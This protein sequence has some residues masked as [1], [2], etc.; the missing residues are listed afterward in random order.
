MV[1]LSFREVSLVGK[2][3]VHGFDHRVV[4]ARVAALL[5]FSKKI[6]GKAGALQEKPRVLIKM[7]FRFFVQD[8]ICNHLRKVEEFLVHSRVIVLSPRD[9]VVADIRVFGAGWHCPSPVSRSMA[10]S[11]AAAQSTQKSSNRHADS[12]ETLPIGGSVSV[13]AVSAVLR[14]EW[15]SI[16]HRAHRRY[17]HRAIWH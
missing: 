1:D 16:P 5:Q 4:E 12:P 17:H 7:Q 14:R 6:F 9:N 10:N 2:R 13:L 15:P 3:T 8:E 11:P